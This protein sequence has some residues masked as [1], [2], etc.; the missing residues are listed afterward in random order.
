[1]ILPALLC[2]AL[3]NDCTVTSKTWAGNEAEPSPRAGV[4]SHALL[5]SC[6][7]LDIVKSSCEEFTAGTR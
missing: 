2:E 3:Y 7:Y 5:C 4:C 6:R 1:M